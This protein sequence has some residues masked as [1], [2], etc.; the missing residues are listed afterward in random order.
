MSRRIISLWSNSVR[1]VADWGP[2]RSSAA[3]CVLH[4]CDLSAAVYCVEGSRLERGCRATKG[5]EQKAVIRRMLCAGSLYGV[6]RARSKAKG[7]MQNRAGTWAGKNERGDRWEGRRSSGNQ[8]ILHAIG[9]G[10]GDEMPQEEVVTR[11]NQR[12]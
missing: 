10:S 6:S 8:C 7:E 12:R 3:K 11:R 5:E 9:T 1:P 2:H 4:G